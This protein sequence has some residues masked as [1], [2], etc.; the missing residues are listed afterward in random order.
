MQTSWV[1]G[2]DTNAVWRPLRESFPPSNP[3]YFTN[4]KIV[5]YF[6]IRRTIDGLPASEGKGMNSSALNLFRCGHLQ[7]IVVCCSL[8]DHICIKAN[9][10]L[11]MRKDHIYKL[12]LFLDKTS[13]DVLSAKCGCPAGKGPH[14]SCKHIGGL[15]YALE[16]YT[17]IKRWPEY[18]TCTDKLQE[19][20]KP[21]PK[22]VDIL[23]VSNLTSRRNNIL[24]KKDSPVD[25]RPPDLRQLSN[26]AIEKFRCDLL[27]LNLH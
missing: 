7:E 25:P 27:S 9:C 13:F 21:R 1:L 26:E 16:E 24:Q 14:A 22:K 18:L 11:E 3:I 2:I 20:N 10:I 12:T 17:P 4:A 19:W 6:V 5:N 15:C 23:S 8:Q